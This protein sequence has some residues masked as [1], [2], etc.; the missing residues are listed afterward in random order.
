MDY[1]AYVGHW[2]YYNFCRVPGSSFSIIAGLK[3][4]CM[5]KEFFRFGRV[6]SGS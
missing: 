2:S 4:K 1:F 6:L 5:V 3:K